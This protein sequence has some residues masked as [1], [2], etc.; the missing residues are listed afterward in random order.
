MPCGRGDAMLSKQGGCLSINCHLAVICSLLVTP[1]KAGRQLEDD[2]S[3]LLESC[4]W[5]DCSEGP[6]SMLKSPVGVFAS[7]DRTG[8]GCDLCHGN[9]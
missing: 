8:R 1:Q 7:S 9:L 5:P 2:S 4:N 3:H 6:H